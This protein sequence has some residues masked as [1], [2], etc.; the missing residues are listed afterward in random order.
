MPLLQEEISNGGPE[1][2]KAKLLL[3]TFHVLTKQLPKALEVLTTVIEEANQETD[4]KVIINALVKR[5][6]LYIQQCQDPKN[7]AVLS[8]ADFDRAAELDP[9]NADVFF[10]RGQINL[11]MDKFEAAKEDLARAAQ[12]REDFALANVQNLYTKFLGS[13]LSGDTSVLQEVE[14]QFQAAVARYPDCVEVYALYAKLLQETGKLKEAD[15][16]YRK[17]LEVNP[18]NANLMV[19]RALLY[20]QQTGDADKALK[21]MNV[22]V[23]LDDKCEFAYETIGQ[24]EI[25]RG[26]LEAAA[27]AFRKAIPLVNTELEMAHLFGLSESASAK[28]LARKKLQEVPTGNN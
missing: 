28:I 23:K 6:S 2:L 24:I 14:Q 22:A 26:N 20:L 12:L 18:E 8:F 27:S 15:E 13:Q 19:Y 21:D 3:G 17:G 1:V 16:L 9:V 4:K 5:G 11:L 25:Q 10:N 7:D